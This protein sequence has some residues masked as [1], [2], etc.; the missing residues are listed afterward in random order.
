MVVVVKFLAGFKTS[1][2]LASSSFLEFFLPF[3]HAS[4]VVVRWRL[5][6][7]AFKAGYLFAL[8]APEVS[9]FAATVVRGCRK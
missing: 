8:M 6:L 9:V 5:V 2:T 3:L 1:E 4:L 7:L